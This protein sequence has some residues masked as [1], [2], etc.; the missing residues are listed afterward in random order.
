MIRIGIYTNKNELDSN[1]KYSWK[2]FV[3][4]GKKFDSAAA[5]IRMQKRVSKMRLHLSGLDSQLH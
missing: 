5:E 2:A 1:K 4:Q 3:S